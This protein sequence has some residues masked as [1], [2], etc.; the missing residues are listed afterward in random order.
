MSYVLVGIYFNHITS[1]VWRKF[2]K[3]WSIEIWFSSFNIIRRVHD[4]KFKL[5]NQPYMYWKVTEF[6]S[7][8]FLSHLERDN[9]LSD[10]QTDRLKT[11]F[12]SRRRN[13]WRLILLRIVRL[14]ASMR[15]LEVALKGEGKEQI[16]TV[17]HAAYSFLVRNN[18]RM[19]SAGTCTVT[20]RSH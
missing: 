9:G 6:E 1:D 7:S 8:V 2:C 11:D 17:G 14:L 10:R 4:A 16:R 13:R 3:H 5:S 15:L 18:G 19:L 20:I 12:I